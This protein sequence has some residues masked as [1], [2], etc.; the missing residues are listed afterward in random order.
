MSLEQIKTISQMPDSLG[1]EFSLVGRVAVITGAASGIGRE[2][3]RVL[4]EAGAQTVISDVNEA[5]LKAT[6]EHMMGA[7]VPADIR[8]ADVSQRSDMDAL[9]DHAVGTWGRVDIWVNVAG[10]MV[11]SPILEMTEDDL[12]R[13]LAINLKGVF[14]GC[15]A[16][17]RV[18]KPVG[19]GSII[20]MSSSGGET[21]V[22]GLSA[23]SM[24][25][26]GVNMLTRTV[27]KEFGP[28]GIRANAIAPGWVDTPMGG[29]RFVDAS[30]AVDVKMREEGL[31]QR[32]GASPL[33]MTGT[34]RDIALAVLYLASDASR[35]MTGQIMRPNGGVSMP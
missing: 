24:A 31:R 21:A 14:W 29:H 7:G 17:G 12:E 19:A 26:A 3:A 8:R 10:I 23:Y 35:F 2:T 34:P 1:A 9:A 13:L 6:A 15:A 16:A 18:M 28:M 11:N 22:P 32:A 20:N 4:A 5:G 25:K 33:G 30:G 27:A